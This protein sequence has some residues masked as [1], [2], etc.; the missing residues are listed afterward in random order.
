MG[1]FI[2]I[3]PGAS[4]GIAALREDRSIVTAARM[5]ETDK[6]ILDLLRAL[7]AESRAVE[8]GFA[9]IERVHAGVFAQNRKM[10]VVSAFSFGGIYRALKMALTAAEIPYDEVTPL[11]WQTALGCR[12]RGDK[13]ITKA[14]AQELF[15]ILPSGLRITHA[16]ADSLLL[17]EYNWRVN[18][19]T[20]G[21]EE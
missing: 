10:G 1:I 21:A 15:P 3:D 8:N 18:R 20:K 13:N 11:K 2:G 6:D 7:A 14:K 5:P 17:A 16:T 12:S 19:L 4:G 9:L